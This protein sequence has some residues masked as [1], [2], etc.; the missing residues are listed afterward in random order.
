[1]WS[2]PSGSCP[3]PARSCCGPSRRSPNP[4]RPGSG[5]RR[6]SCSSARSVWRCRRTVRCSRC[7]G[8]GGSRRLRQ[9]SSSGPGLRFRWPCVVD[10]RAPKFGDF[11]GVP[12]AKSL[13]SGYP[14]QVLGW[15][16][17]L[18]AFRSY[19]S[20]EM[21]KSSGSQRDVDTIKVSR[22]RFLER[23]RCPRQAS[24]ADESH[25]SNQRRQNL[26]RK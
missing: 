24:R 3:A 22:R 17:S 26:P 13:G 25:L 7:R 10:F 5:S 16:T 6:L 14:L 8:A 21:R 18:R 1:M 9:R 23:C 20:R 12:L 15:I 2:A 4:R 11:L 19:P